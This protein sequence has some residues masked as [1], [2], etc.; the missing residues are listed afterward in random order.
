MKILHWEFSET[1]DSYYEHCSKTLSPMPKWIYTDVLPEPY[2]SSYQGAYHPVTGDIYLQK[3]MDVKQAEVVAAHELTHA[4]KHR[5]H[6][7]ST[8]SINDEYWSYVGSKLYGCLLDV[9]VFQTLK[10]FG[11]DVSDEMNL[12]FSMITSL[13]QFPSGYERLPVLAVTFVEYFYHFS[14]N[15][16]LWSEIVDVYKTFH[17]ASLIKGLSLLKVTKGLDFSDPQQVH[18]ILSEWISILGLTG[19]VELVMPIDLNPELAR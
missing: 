10:K 14:D 15:Q 12:R 16:S 17:Q 13:P 1:F 6:P 11:F 5:F 9:D 4:T 8:T 2:K 7:A 18:K 3:S 19:L